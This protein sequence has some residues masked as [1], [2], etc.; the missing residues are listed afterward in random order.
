[1]I[2]SLHRGV[3]LWKNGTAAAVVGLWPSMLLLGRPAVNAELQEQYH[4]HQWP[5]NNGGRGP[6]C[7]CMCSTR[8]CVVLPGAEHRHVLAAPSAHGTLHHSPGAPYVLAVAAAA[9]AAAAAA[10]CRGG[11]GLPTAF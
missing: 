11:Y 6:N 1:M 4:Y 2:P 10:T 7:L 5:A 8:W 3:V 9:A